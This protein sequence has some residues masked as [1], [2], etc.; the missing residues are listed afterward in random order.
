M[1]RY[2]W[3]SSQTE[4]PQ[5]LLSNSPTTIKTTC[6]SLCSDGI[7]CALV[8]THCLLSC[9]QAQ[10]DIL[11]IAPTTK[12]ELSRISFWKCRDLFSFIRSFIVYTKLEFRAPRN[13]SP[14]LDTIIRWS[15]KRRT[16]SGPNKFILPEAGYLKEKEQVLKWS[17]ETD[18]GNVSKIS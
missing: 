4:T 14:S 1:S 5:P 2:G 16:A 8:C 17:T 18:A 3:V 10:Q 12:Q 7:S 6:T 13:T 11:L 15:L 9:H